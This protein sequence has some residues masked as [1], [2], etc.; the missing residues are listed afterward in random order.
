M[1]SKCY[2]KI[3]RFDFSSWI[4]IVCWLS[5]KYIISTHFRDEHKQRSGGSCD[6]KKTITYVSMKFVGNWDWLTMIFFVRYKTSAIITIMSTAKQNGKIK[7]LR[8]LINNFFF[9]L[10]PLSLWEVVARLCSLK[11]ILVYLT[12][13]WFSPYIFVHSYK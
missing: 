8:K 13:R 9:L 2:K 4:S 5:R 1:Q 10:W 6:W 12:N 7:I 3:L 11:F